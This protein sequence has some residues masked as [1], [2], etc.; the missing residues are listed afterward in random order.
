MW[1]VPP[2]VVTVAAMAWVGWV[3]REG[4]GHVGQDE[5]LRRLGAA[6]EREPSVSHTVARPPRESSTGV[7]VRRRP[8]VP[9]VQ[10]PTVEAPGTDERGEDRPDE[11]RRAS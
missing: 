7:A 9:P 1:L 4:R 10:P 6:L 5:A 11:Q 3:G 8:E 2:L